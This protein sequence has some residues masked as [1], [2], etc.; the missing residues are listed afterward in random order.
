MHTD[1]IENQ[2][3]IN[4]NNDYEDEM[5]SKSFN[6]DIKVPKNYINKLDVTIDQLENMKI[7]L[8]DLFKTHIENYESTKLLYNQENNRNRINHDQE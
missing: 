4:E 7:Y 3:K 6:N 8:N 1:K 5:Y 2:T